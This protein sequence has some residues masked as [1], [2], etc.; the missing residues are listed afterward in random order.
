MRAAWLAELRGKDDA[1]GARD[2][3]AL[4]SAAAGDRRF[5]APAWQ[6]PELRIDE[7]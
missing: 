1:P 4:A 6:T 7:R 3:G 5:A 2:R